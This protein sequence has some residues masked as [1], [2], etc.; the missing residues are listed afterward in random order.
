MHVATRGRCFNKGEFTLIN[1]S[2]VPLNNPLQAL[3]ACRLYKYLALE[4]AEDYLEIEVCEDFKNY[5]R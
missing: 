3:I 2:T 5:A 4:A 1:L